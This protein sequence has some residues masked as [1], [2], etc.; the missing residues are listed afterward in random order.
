MMCFVGMPTVFYGDELGVQGLREEEYRA[1]MPWS[2]G[3]LALLGFFRKAIA[4]RHELPALREGDFQM[5]SADEGSRV[6]RFRRST[7]MCSVTVSVNAGTTD[8]AIPAQEGKPYWAEGFRDGIL[9]PGGFLVTS[10][11][12]TCE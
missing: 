1:P 10:S 2:G 3:D 7:P 9:A 6:L 11:A 8:A 5:L 4:M 12:G